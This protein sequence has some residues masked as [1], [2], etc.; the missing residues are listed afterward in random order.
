VVASDTG[1]S[2]AAAGDDP[3]GVLLD[4]GEGTT[5]TYSRLPRQIGGSVVTVEPLRHNK[6]NAAT[7]GIWRVRGSGGSAVL[8]IASPPP[9]SPVGFWPTS[10]DPAHWNYWRRESL[11]Y[12]SGLAATAYGEAGITPPDLLE[13][14]VRADGLV[15][16]WLD[17][18]GGTEGFDWP[19]PRIARFAYELGAGQARW[20]GRVPEYAWLSRRWLAQYLAEGP[21]LSVE[22]E[23]SYW[24]HPRVAAWPTQ[25]R[26]E[27]RWLWGERSRLL[28]AAEAAERTLCHLDVWPA[29]L[30]DSQGRSVLLD[31]SFAGEGAVGE[32]LANLILD[33]F[34]DGLMDV[35][36]L[37][38][39][40]ETTTDS[41]LQGLRDGGWSGSED[42]LRTAIAACGAAKYSWLGPAV[43]G[44]AVRDDL[45]TSSYN[46]DGSAEEAVRRVA[47]LVALIA[48]WAGAV[49]V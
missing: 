42:G 7:H 6:G 22:I 28:A 37:P 16:L 34:T 40:A 17:D 25:V 21:S 19:A 27:L 5:V 33:S 18:V 38:E 31:W 23:D 36:L 2:D 48:D 11:A 12:T 26:Q 30:I 39:V 20:A 14:N 3:E 44:R 13:A 41:Y 29:N 49:P 46:R 10:D 15:E 8:K 1:N 9:A 4:A 47:G 35:T 32:D 45:G 43:L 24:D